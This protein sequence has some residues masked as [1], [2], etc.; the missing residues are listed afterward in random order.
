MTEAREALKG[1]DIT[2]M[3]QAQERLQA[4]AHKL[5]EAMYRE[6]QSASAPGGAGGR[7]S[8][9]GGTTGPKAGEVV[10]AEFEDLGEKKQG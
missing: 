5:A 3:K 4:A 1:E 7:P 8:A 10:D 9:G 2:R 6:A